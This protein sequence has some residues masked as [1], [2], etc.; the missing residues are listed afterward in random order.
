LIAVLQY[1][2]LCEHHPLNKFHAEKAEEATAR[3]VVFLIDAKLLPCALLWPVGAAAADRAVV[4]AADMDAV[5]MAVER[6][7]VC[8]LEYAARDPR[9]ADIAELGIGDA[10]IPDFRRDE[11]V[12]A[13]IGIAKRLLPG[14]A[15]AYGVRA[16]LRVR[17]VYA[18]LCP[19][20]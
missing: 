2:S 11:R 20:L 1:A 17:V 6:P 10:Q 4:R 5:R 9:A 12:L 13:R 3:A 19:A 18:I 8:A 14:D 7:V 15:H 16:A